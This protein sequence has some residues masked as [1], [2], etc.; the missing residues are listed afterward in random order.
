[1]LV[2]DINA[3]DEVFAGLGNAAPPS[4]VTDSPI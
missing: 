4:A 3:I 1:M 2:V